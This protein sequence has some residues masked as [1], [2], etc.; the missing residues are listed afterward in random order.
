MWNSSFSIKYWGEWDRVGDI[1]ARSRIPLNDF[2]ITF[3][4]LKTIFVTI[5]HFSVF[6]IFLSLFWGSF[7]V[8][9]MRWNIVLVRTDDFK[10]SLICGLPSRRGQM[11]VFGQMFNVWWLESF[12]GNLKWCLPSSIAHFV[13]LSRQKVKCK[14]YTS[15]SKHPAANCPLSQ[16]I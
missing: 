13:D 1:K 8:S 6:S 2:Y 4:S 10:W 15:L 5:C 16:C 14:I 3:L 7:F 11:D 12:R 9:H